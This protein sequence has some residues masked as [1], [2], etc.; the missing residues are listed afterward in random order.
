MIRRIIILLLIVG[1]EESNSIPIVSTPPEV[2]PE[3]EVV[4]E[5]TEYFSC[6]YHINYYEPIAGI[7]LPINSNIC[8]FI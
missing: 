4:P 7:L 1:C 6:T 5:Y 3:H 8:L 2:V